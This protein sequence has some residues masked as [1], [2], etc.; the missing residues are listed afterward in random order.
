MQIGDL[1]KRI[2]F[3]SSTKTADGMGGFSVVW[4]AIPDPA[5]VWAGIWPVSASEQIQANAT[6][7]TISHRIRIRYQ[8]GIK[9][10]YRIKFGTRYFA[11]VSIINPNERN[12]WLDLICKEAV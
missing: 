8:S 9:G 12:E 5:T 4:A 3:Q 2:T 6:T 7:M 10:S 1:N 11:I